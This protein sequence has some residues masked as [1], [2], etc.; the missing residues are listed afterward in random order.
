MKMT[1]QRDGWHRN[2][3]AKEWTDG[4]YKP[5]LNY[6][7]LNNPIYK[8]KSINTKMDY[9]NGGSEGQRQTDRD[10]KGDRVSE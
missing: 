5:K 9:M 4:L 8:N 6:I 2:N 10:R 7:K 3:S 1:R